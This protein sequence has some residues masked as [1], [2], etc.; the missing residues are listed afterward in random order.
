M[1]IHLLIVIS[2]VYPQ[3][4]ADSLILPFNTNSETSGLDIFPLQMSS[5]A[6][7][8]FAPREKSKARSTRQPLAIY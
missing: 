8:A 3:T 7:E 2:H 5:D 6:L 1:A 4:T